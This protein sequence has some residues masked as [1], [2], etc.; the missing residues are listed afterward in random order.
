MLAGAS[1]IAILSNLNVSAQVALP[2]W[3]RARGLSVFITVFFGSMTLG[4]L[5]W[6]QMAG[7]FGI[8]A[9]LI[10][11]AAGAVLGIVVTRPFKLQQGADLDLAPSMHWPAPMTAETVEPDRGPVMVTIEYRIDPKDGAAFL[12]ALQTLADA[13]RRDGAFAWGIFEDVAIPGR[14]LEYF[15]EDSWLEHL[16]H[17]E[18]VT[19][20]DRIAQELV[21]TYH[22]GDDTPRVSHFL[23]PA[24]VGEN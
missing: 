18:R 21:H 14:Y 7:L 16:R 4:S 15:M 10:T 9:A 20:S 1:W 2:E 23:A 5:I 3:V 12:K 11:A 13:R 19:G 6:G 8:P 24:P 22:Q 17:H